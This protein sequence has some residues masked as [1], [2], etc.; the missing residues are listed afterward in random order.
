MSQ[1]I[2][3]KPHRK[4]VAKNSGKTQVKAPADPQPKPKG[5]A[6][7]KADFTAEGSPPPGFVAPGTLPAVDKPHA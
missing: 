7:E 3:A 5:L 6:Q 4:P 1:T 2:A